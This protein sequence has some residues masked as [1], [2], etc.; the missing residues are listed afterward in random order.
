V[1]RRLGAGAVGLVLA[2]A[3]LAVAARRLAT[4]APPGVGTVELT[5]EAGETFA[6]VASRL[7]R[8]GLVVSARRVRVLARLAALDRRIHAGT[9]RLERGRPPLRL[10]D[11]LA[12][13][14]VL[15]RR[16]IIPEGLRLQQI[17]AAV[18]DSLGVSAESVLAAA[19]DAERLRRAG[20]RG[21]TLE[22]YLFPDTY[23]FGEGASAGDVVDAMLARFE[24]VWAGLPRGLPQGLDRH[25][26]VTLASIVEAE[27]PLPAEKP[28]VAAVYLNRLRAGWRLQADPTVR[29]G[30]GYRDERLYY[31]QLAID[32][33]YNTYLR[34]GL[35]P[36]PIGSPG[37]EA[38][39]AVLAPME[40]CADFYFVAS[41]EGGHVF[42]RTKQEHDR[43]RRAARAG[44]PG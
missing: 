33:P 25:D 19:R 43:A 38:L 12:H 42:S 3:A 7:E 41:G 26:V 5:V 36:G 2:L 40:P 11:D 31:K 1:R 17:A 8:E 44:S 20:A 37:R 18:Q 34:D 23:L 22:G 4:E 9:Y 13:G 16:L 10:L 14:R 21:E 27:T 39:A 29:Y 15:L 35:P 30:L 28:R 24:E 32:T 6:G